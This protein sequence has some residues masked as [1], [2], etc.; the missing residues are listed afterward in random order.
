[1]TQA[2]Y[3]YLKGESPLLISSPLISGALPPAP[4]GGLDLSPRLALHAWRTHAAFRCP[5]KAMPGSMSSVATTSTSG[6]TAAQWCK[7]YFGVKSCKS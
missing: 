3:R 6:V 7:W 4:N 1:M 5:D 2:H